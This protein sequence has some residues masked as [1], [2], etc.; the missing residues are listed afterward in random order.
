M[1]NLW[2]PR[3]PRFFLPFLECEVCHR[4]V[5]ADF[6]WAYPTGLI[7]CIPCA[8]KRINLL[9]HRPRAKQHAGQPAPP[10]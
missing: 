4:M 2:S 3:D 8:G 9:G 6:A 1:Q 10:E 5:R 7:K